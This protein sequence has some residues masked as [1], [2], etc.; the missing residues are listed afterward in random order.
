MNRLDP[1]LF[2]A[3]FSSWVAACWLAPQQQSKTGQKALHLVSAF[4]TE[5][6][7]V[8]GQEAVFEKSN[9]I[10]A[11]PALIERLD[12]KGTLVSIDRCHGM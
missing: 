11:I 9:E 3:C 1:D 10:T 8:I 2:R 4:A 6:Q 5:S 7:L 12:L